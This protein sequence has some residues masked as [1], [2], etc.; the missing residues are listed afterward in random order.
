MLSRN[1][2]HSDLLQPAPAP[3]SFQ[4][5]DPVQREHVYIIYRDMRNDGATASY[6]RCTNAS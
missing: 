4:L 6:Y 1:L 2:H 3:A 5:G